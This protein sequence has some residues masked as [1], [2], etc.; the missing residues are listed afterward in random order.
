MTQLQNLD[1]EALQDSLTYLM[2]L[3]THQGQQLVQ[4]RLRS[5]QEQ[6]QRQLETSDRRY[7]LYRS[8]GELVAYRKAMSAITDLIDQIKRELETK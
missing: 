5:L 6:A 4:M 7:Q 1:K 3:Q 2:E 8:Q